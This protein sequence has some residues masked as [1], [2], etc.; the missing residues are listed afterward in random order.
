MKK[1]FAAAMTIAGLSLFSMAG[2][3]TKDDCSPGSRKVSGT[4]ADEGLARKARK[5]IAH[6]R[7]TDYAIW[8]TCHGSKE[9]VK[10]GAVYKMV[11][12]CLDK[13]IPTLLASG[14]TAS[15]SEC[16]MR[17]AQL[18]YAA[19]VEKGLPLDFDYSADNDLYREISKNAEAVKCQEISRNVE[20]E[21]DKHGLNRIGYEDWAP[22]ILY[23]LMETAGKVPVPGPAIFILRPEPQEDACGGDVEVKEPPK[24]CA[25]VSGCL[26]KP[27]GAE[28]PG[29][30]TGSGGGLPPGTDPG[31]PPGGGGDGL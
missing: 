26:D 9:P 18:T 29:A 30:S 5:E 22:A 15:L 7:E 11:A 14:M 23:L 1:M 19:H 24:K 20:I 31:V 13:V 6:G 10:I 2:C 27:A 8:F 16:L 28:E 17:T 12:L 3:S 25:D 21:A 4:E